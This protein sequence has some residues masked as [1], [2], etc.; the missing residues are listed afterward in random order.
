MGTSPNA[1]TIGLVGTVLGMLVAI[2]TLANPIF[3]LHSRIDLLS[4]RLEQVERKLDK[5][6]ERRKGD[7]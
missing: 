6:L 5:D 3:K 2:C 4:Y 7:E 1:G